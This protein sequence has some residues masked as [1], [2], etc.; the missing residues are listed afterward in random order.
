MRSSH[1][2]GN[3]IKHIALTVKTAKP[4]SRDKETPAK[5]LAKPALRPQQ[6]KE[7]KR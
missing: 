3:S 1:F 5:K 2:E 6:K 4:F 7:R